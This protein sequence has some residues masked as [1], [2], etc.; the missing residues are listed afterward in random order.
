[1]LRQVRAAWRARPRCGARRTAQPAR[2]AARRTALRSR[3]LGGVHPRAACNNGLVGKNLRVRAVPHTFMS[4]VIPA[5]RRRI[6]RRVALLLVIT[7]VPA[8]TGAVFPVVP[9]CAGALPEPAYAP[10]GGAPT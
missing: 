1:M 7:A 4:A 9:P 8:A 3:E 2:S 10:L 5:R 6:G